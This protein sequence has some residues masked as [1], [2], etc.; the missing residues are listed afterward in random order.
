MARYGDEFKDRALAR[1]LPPET[2]E[3][4]GISTL[5][6]PRAAE[7]PGWDR[8]VDASIGA[9]G[10]FSQWGPTQRRRLLRRVLLANAEA[11]CTASWNLVEQSGYA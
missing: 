7:G 2:A 8:P 9:R 1:L 6:H 4:S 10:R 3:I 5:L 11:I